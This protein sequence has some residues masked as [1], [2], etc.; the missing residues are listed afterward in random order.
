MLQQMSSKF[1]DLLIQAVTF[2]EM[3]VGKPPPAGSDMRPETTMKE[4]FY[5]MA[6]L[7]SLLHATVL[8]ECRSDPDLDHIKTF[9]IDARASYSKGLRRTNSRA[10]LDPI[11]KAFLVSGKRL[12]DDPHLYLEVIEGIDDTERNS[13]ERVNVHNRP[14]VVLVWIHRALVARIREGG[15]P[16]A[17]PIL[18]RTFQ[19]ISNGTMFGNHCIKIVDTPFPFPY[20]QLVQ[21]LLGTFMLTSPVVITEYAQQR[22]IACCLSFLPHSRTLVSRKY[23]ESWKDRLIPTRTIWTWCGSRN[24]SIVTS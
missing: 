12:L 18:S 24:S 2:D 11:R 20:N 13:L 19:V 5:R 1:N 7:V 8:M 9:N 16:I 15:L 10:E 14:Q 4:F 23:H 3:C 6:H 21:F 17:P 22:W